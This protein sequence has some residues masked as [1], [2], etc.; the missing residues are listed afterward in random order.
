MHSYACTSSAQSRD[1]L[2][3]VASLL[4][5]VLS[6]SLS[7]S[8]S[9]P[10]PPFKLLPRH[11]CAQTHTDTPHNISWH[12]ALGPPPCR[13]IHFCAWSWMFSAS[14]EWRGLTHTHTHTHNLSHLHPPM[15]TH[16]SVYDDDLD[17]FGDDED[18]VEVAVPK[19][20]T[21]PPTRQS[22]PLPR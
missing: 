19:K 20:K 15:C 13:P 17:D 12:V 11:H 5:C 18:E 14:N 8:L 4:S 7:L 2:L 3:F 21:A 10:S 16:S 9:P 1:S 22:Q 6:L